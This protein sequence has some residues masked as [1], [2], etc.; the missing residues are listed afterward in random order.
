MRMKHLVARIVS[1][2][3]AAALLVTSLPDSMTALAAG[4]GKS[5]RSDYGVCIRCS[6]ASGQ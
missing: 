3:A 1:T 5:G 2:V 6:H 4:G